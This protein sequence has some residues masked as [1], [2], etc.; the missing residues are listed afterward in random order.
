[1]SIELQTFASGDTD[2]ISKL[3]ANV[4]ALTD[5]INALQTQIGSMSGGSAL[6]TGML[7]N[8]LFNGADALIGTTSYSPQKRATTLTIQPGG[9]YLV[10]SQTVVSS[11][12]AVPLNFTGQSAG[13]YYIVVATS[14]QPTRMTTKDPGAI[15]SVVWTGSGFGQITYLVPIFYD[16]TEADAS[17]RS[18]AMSTT[19]GEKQFNTLDAR[20]EQAETAAMDAAESAGNAMSVAY[21]LEAYV[22]SARYRKVGIT[23]D[24]TTGVKGAIQIDFG[25]T[26]VGWSIIGNMIGSIQVEVDLHPS[27]A[28]P[29]NPNVPNT[30]TDKIS[31]NAPIKLTGN[32]SASTAESGVATWM[33]NLAKWDV[34]QFNVISVDT[35]T[36]ATLYLRILE[37]MPSPPVINPLEELEFDLSPLEFREGDR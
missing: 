32:K 35:L 22:T 30:T 1:M 27:S 4:A 2:Y 11:F 3:N 33:H 14:G 16:T 20:M 28:P 6:S 9:M 21:E 31:A 24:G 12:I 19:S 36:Q 8:T 34:I 13:T 29:A 10:T 5:A 7:M 17:R 23:V 25:G 18:L 37:E 15:Y 26:I